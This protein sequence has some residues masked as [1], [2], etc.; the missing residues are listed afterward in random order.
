[1][2]SDPAATLAAA[3]PADPADHGPIGVDSDAV[4]GVLAELV[5]WRKTDALV[6]RQ[7]AEYTPAE[8]GDA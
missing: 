3:L 8:D 5:E 4:R 7:A 6:A 2:S 1:M